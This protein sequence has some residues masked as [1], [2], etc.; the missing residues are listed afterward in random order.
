MIMTKHKEWQLRIESDGTLLWD[1]SYLGLT[2]IMTTFSSALSADTVYHVVCTFDRA[3]TTS[4]I[5]LNGVLNTTNTTIITYS[6]GV[7]STEPLQIGRRS[8]DGGNEF[9]GVIGHVAIYPTV[10]SGARILAHY[11]AGI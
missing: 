6:D 10:L 5:Y 9:I 2:A 3:A 7:N 1:V 4:K 8:D 11:T